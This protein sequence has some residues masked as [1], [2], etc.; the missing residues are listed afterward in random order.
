MPENWRAWCRREGDLAVA[1]ERVTVAL[2][3]GRTHRV[4]I[5]EGADSIELESVVVRGNR[6]EEVR[7]PEE[8][9]WTRNRLS[10]RVGFRFDTR[11]RLL[12]FCWLPL[13]GLTK[14]EFLAELRHLAQEA[15]LF[16]FQLTGSDRE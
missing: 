15:D 4:L 12:A 2:E 5:R 10:K 7:E 14:S 6:L 9:I 16:E 3:D 11:D 8:V 1:G 13:A